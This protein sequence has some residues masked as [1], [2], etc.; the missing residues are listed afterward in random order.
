MRFSINFFTSIGL[1]GLTDNMR[2]HLKNIPRL[3]AQ[4]AAGSDSDDSSSSSSGANVNPNLHPAW[5]LMSSHH[6]LPPFAVSNAHVQA[7][8][9]TDTRQCEM[10]PGFGASVSAG[11]CNAC[12]TV[13]TGCVTAK[14][15][16]DAAHPCIICRCTGSCVLQM[17]LRHPTAHPTLTHPALLGQAHPAQTQG[18]TQTRPALQ[19]MR[20]LQRG[21]RAKPVCRP[22]LHGPQ[23]M[24]LTDGTVIQS[25]AI[26][27]LPALFLSNQC[28]MRRVTCNGS[29]PV[30]ACMLVS[31]LHSNLPWLNAQEQHIYVL[32]KL[33]RDMLRC[34]CCL[35]EH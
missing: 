4:P 12:S 30:S 20:H 6:P 24:E 15:K 25:P 19:R 33:D 31:R 26:Q 27:N 13:T 8:A 14:F 35:F 21:G 5:Q 22:L 2:E 1:G 32:H 17:I 10:A 34:Q 28:H 29:F 9:D 7:T 11:L 16:A 23:A 3:I 18:P